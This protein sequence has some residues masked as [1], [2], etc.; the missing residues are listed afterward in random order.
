VKNEIT[1]KIL[2]FPV[3]LLTVPPVNK[4]IEGNLKLTQI[5]NIR[6]EDLLEREPIVLNNKL[7]KEKLEGKSILVTGAAGSI[8]SEL[9]RQLSKFN[10]NKILL[11]DNAESALYE[12]EMEL[13]EN[14]IPMNFEIIL[15]DIRVKNRMQKVFEH[16]KPQVIFHA[17]AYK[18]VPMMENNPSEALAVNISGTKIIADLAHEFHAESLIMISTDK[19]VNPTNVMGASKRIAEIYCSALNEKSNTNFITTR[20]GNVFESNGSVI[21]RFKKQIERGGPVTVTH[22][23]ITRY[24][25]TIPEACQLVLEASVMGKGG[26]VFVFDMGKPVKIL[27]LAK[28][29]IKLGQTTA[30]NEIKIEFT[31]LRPGEKLYEEL[32]ANNENTL[33]THHEKILIAKVENYEFEKINSEIEN[34]IAL[35]E[36]QDNIE[37]VKSMKKLVPEFKS[38]NSEFV[39]L[40]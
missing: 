37:I 6:I 24:F 21:P 18:H 34:L 20:F 29:M 35:F 12:I 33:P 30:S 36:D 25:M 22:P 8:G 39:K 7:L 9:V 31:G 19:A 23:E 5:K 40:D 2:D 16:F 27:D 11:L 14:K 4:W 15:A 26:E 17:A 10:P 38:N 3:K 13:L 28:K 32:L 1:E